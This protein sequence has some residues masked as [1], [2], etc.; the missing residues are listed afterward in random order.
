MNQQPF[1]GIVQIKKTGMGSGGGRV[2]VNQEFKVLYNLKKN[3][4]VVVRGSGGRCDQT[5]LSG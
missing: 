4:N 2:G 3:K 5:A 1:P